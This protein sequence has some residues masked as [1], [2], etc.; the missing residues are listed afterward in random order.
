MLDV[1]YVL[2]DR[3]KSGIIEV[4]PFMHLAVVAERAVVAA[5]VSYKGNQLTLVD[6]SSV[7]KHM[8]K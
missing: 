4:D 8:I 1:Q 3:S 6:V 5:I 2:T 7:R